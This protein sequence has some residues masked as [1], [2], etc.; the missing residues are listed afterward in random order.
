MADIIQHRRDTSANWAE[1]NPILLEG[2]IG[3]C[4]DNPNLYKIGDGVHD[5]K[6]LPFRGFTGTISQS[7]GDDENA[8][9]SQKIVTDQFVNATMEY[10]V[11]K[12]HPTSGIEGSNKYTL[13]TAIAQV[14]SEYRTIGLKCSFVGEEGQGETW[15][16]IG[17]GWTVDNFR[18]A[19]A[20]KI[21]E[22]DNVDCNIVEFYSSIYPKYVVEID[23][24]EKG[25]RI[26]GSGAKIEDADYQI[27]TG[28]LSKG[29]YAI[30]G[31]YTGGTG[32]DLF[33]IQITDTELGTF[34]EII[35][36]GNTRINK[37][38]KVENTS[39]YRICLRTIS[40]NFRIEREED[41]LSYRFNNIVS[42]PNPPMKLKCNRNKIKDSSAF[43]VGYY[44]GSS[45]EELT[46]TDYAISDYINI[47]SDS[48]LYMFKD[49][50]LSNSYLSGQACICF[51]NAFKDLIGSVKSQDFKDL[52]TIE[53]NTAGAYYV[54]V[55][56]PLSTPIIVTSELAYEFSFKNLAEKGYVSLQ[57]DDSLLESVSIT[58]GYFL[59]YEGNLQANESY[60]YTDFIDVDGLDYA[61]LFININ[62]VLNTVT[63]GAHL[64][65][66]D[67]TGKFIKSLS[68]NTIKESK[69]ISI[70]IPVL[71]KKLRLSLK[72]EWNGNLT[73]AKSISLSKKN[74]V[75]INDDYYI[76]NHQCIDS[77]PVSI[78]GITY[79]KSNTII[80]AYL[81]FVTFNTIQIRRGNGMFYSGYVDI[82]FDT[83]KLSCGS[84][85]KT[86]NHE[87]TFDQYLLVEIITGYTADCVIRLTTNGDTK[88]FVF[89]T[90]YADGGVDIIGYAGLIIE[91]ASIRHTNLTR[92]VTRF[93]GD[94]YS[95]TSSSKRW[96][97]YVMR[98]KYNLLVN[99]LTGGNSST[100]YTQ[101]IL[102]IQRG[103]I[104][105]R[106]IWGLGMNDTSDSGDESPSST[107]LSI[108]NNLMS[109]CMSYG[110]ELILC[111][112]PNVP[113]R[114][115]RGK[116]TYVRNSGYRYID[117]AKA[118]G[119]DDNTSWT[120]DMLD[121]DELHP[122]EL[123]AMALYSEAICK[124]PEI[125][126]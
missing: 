58:E 9:I 42:L 12:F 36:P 76:T 55:S 10:N 78:S 104:P 114:N 126:Q 41:V 117:F 40:S 3:Y 107:W 95:S 70:S 59:D 51:Y 99:G 7:L 81:K 17:G 92:K 27:L 93:Y 46:N 28:T 66:Y 73:F 122:T 116:N 61:Y 16:Y 67:A 20:A 8:V 37:I 14:P 112:I 105:Q 68:Y 38:I 125:V 89:D 22:L 113:G 1:E 32:N 13:E 26:N 118:V 86:Y 25:Y 115:N 72:N 88:D 123:G 90:F 94:S 15:E 96:P 62:G 75:S 119:S 53:I 5:W 56:F 24:I 87:M 82:S 11:S 54:R 33:A 45:G 64:C 21:T 85:T 39:T 109:L 79:I 120:D 108:V 111:T 2:E 18:Q 4:T 106:I 63:G 43:T 23:N 110:I 98:N 19:G 31:L 29:L 84:Y 52:Q 100:L 30:H 103:G 50:G 91:S 121:S 57:G 102:D 124:V 83:I 65:F 48:K 97:Y 60:S 77:K 34:Y 47:N 44:L 80:A 6:S 69:S 35:N 101:V 71:A 74:S 49:D